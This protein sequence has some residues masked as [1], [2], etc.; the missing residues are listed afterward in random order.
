MGTSTITFSFLNYVPIQLLDA[1]WLDPLNGQV[2][3][4]GGIQLIITS[5]IHFFSSIW[6][7]A[8]MAVDIMCMLLSSFILLQLI[9]GKCL[10]LWW[11]LLLTQFPLTFCH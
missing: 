4:T 8:C 11:A 9:F 10:C 1:L 7:H 5:H 2:I 3:I 6:A